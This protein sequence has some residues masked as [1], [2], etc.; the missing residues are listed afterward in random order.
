MKHETTSSAAGEEGG[1]TAAMQPLP[2]SDELISRLAGRCEEI[3]PL[4]D[5]LRHDEISDEEIHEMESLLKR[6]RPAPVRVLFPIFQAFPWRLRWAPF[7]WFKIR[8]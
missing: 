1:G 8:W 4:N 7:C 6:L 2:V 3:F 5:R